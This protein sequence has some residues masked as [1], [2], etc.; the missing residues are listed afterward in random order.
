MGIIYA[1]S[2]SLQTAAP[3]VHG[4]RLP[5]GELLVLRHKARSL[6]CSARLLCDDIRCPYGH[7]CPYA[8][9]HC[10]YGDSCR[11]SD[12]HGIET[13]RY[14][15][16]SLSKDQLLAICKYGAN[17]SRQYPFR[18]LYASGLQENLSTQDSA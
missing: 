12:T 16:Q 11:F 17:H 9:R 4:P 13:V 18:K 6:R 5:E 7:N 3:N 1:A 10:T 2:V 14:P 15:N 8:G